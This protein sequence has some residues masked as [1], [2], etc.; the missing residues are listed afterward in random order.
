M[1]CFRASLC[2]LQCPDI[3][4]SPVGLFRRPQHF[5]YHRPESQV[6][7]VVTV[8]FLLHREPRHVRGNDIMSGETLIAGYLQVTRQ[9]NSVSSKEAMVGII[10]SKKYFL[11]P[12]TG[13]NVTYKILAAG[14][15]ETFH[16]CKLKVGLL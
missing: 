8:N 7:D 14:C 5:P 6:E 16:G 10:K 4:I 13:S 11:F 9:F 1:S 3:H 15:Q 12:T 2:F